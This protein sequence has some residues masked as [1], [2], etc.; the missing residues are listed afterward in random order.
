MYSKDEERFS[1]DFSAAYCKLTE[2]GV[3]TKPIVSLFLL[4]PTVLHPTH[5]TTYTTSK[6]PFDNKSSMTPF[7]LLA[8]LTA[9]ATRYG[10]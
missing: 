2:L 3:C 7:I 8:G 6:V 4:T 10:Q 9:L 5:I 1:K